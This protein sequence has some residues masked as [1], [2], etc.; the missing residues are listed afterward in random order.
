MDFGNHPIY[1]VFIFICKLSQMATSPL[2]KVIPVDN[3][4]GR[5]R[6]K[7][8]PTP[9]HGINWEQWE[10]S[11]SGK[12]RSRVSCL[13]EKIRVLFSILHGRHF[14]M[15]TVWC[16]RRWRSK[17]AILGLAIMQAV[18]FPSP[19]LFDFICIYVYIYMFNCSFT[20]SVKRPWALWIKG[21]I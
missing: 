9:T 8:R 11:F 2:N 6:P 19:F 5:E 12:A 1:F 7:L 17:H 13:M 3:W 18:C 21:A 15:E 14:A 16:H 4:W 10:W 20:I